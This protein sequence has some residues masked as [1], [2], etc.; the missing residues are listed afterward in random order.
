MR[1]I[2]WRGVG[3]L[4]S[5]GLLAGCAAGANAAPTWVPQPSIT[6]EA[7]PPP[8]APDQAPSQGPSGPQGPL[9]NAPGSP[10]TP[11]GGAAGQQSGRGQQ[12]YPPPRDP[13]HE[14]Q[15]A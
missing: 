8:S 2:P 6:L 4:A 9:P 12:P 3:L 14:G 11:G 5:A 10:R 1:R 13:T 7:T 15:C